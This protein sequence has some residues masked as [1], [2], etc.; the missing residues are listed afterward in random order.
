MAPSTKVCKRSVVRV[1]ATARDL[2]AAMKE[3]RIGLTSRWAAD[4]TSALD[5]RQA[6]LDR[7][8]SAVLQL[9]ERM[10]ACPALGLAHV[11]RKVRLLSAIHPNGEGARSW[12]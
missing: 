1:G 5:A 10:L 7:C 12:R 11:L 9:A 4:G 2:A 6:E 3:E 8:S